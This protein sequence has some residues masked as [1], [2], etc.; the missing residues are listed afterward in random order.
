MTNYRDIVTQNDWL[1]R[2]VFDSLGNYL[3]CCQCVCAA[4]GIYKDRITRQRNV[5]R[6]W[7]Q[8]PIV[9]MLK[10]EAE[11]EKR[12]GQYV[13]MP[14]DEDANF[15][16]WWRGLAGSTSVQVRQKDT[17]MRGKGQ[18]TLSD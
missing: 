10:T 12:L 13:V 17:L 14:A 16:T 15:K 4:L 5:K 7:Y 3:Y 2:N 11:E 6:Q 18:L 8:E 9:E 1:G